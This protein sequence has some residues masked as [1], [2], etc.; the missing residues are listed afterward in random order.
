[1]ETGAQGMRRFEGRG[2]I[3]TGGASGIG[4]ATARRFLAEG[5]RVLIADRNE[6]ALRAAFPEQTGEAPVRTRV[7]DVSDAASVTAMV[8][9]ARA[10]LP[11]LDVLINNAGIATPERFFEISEASWDRTLSTNLKGMFLVGQAVA[12]AMAEQGG[13][14]IVNTASTNGLVG[15][16][17]YA[18]YNA[19]K[20]GVVLLTKSMAIDLAPHGIRVNAVAPGFIRT[21]LTEGAFADEAYFAAYARNKIPLGRV[22]RP[23]EMAA[24]FAFLASDDASFITG[25]TIVADGGQMTS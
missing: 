3:V 2:V 21:P 13:G 15:E 20:G 25:E 23:E 5:A 18:H 6:A 22:G 19:S 8:E 14:A 10:W 16:E 11:R 24:V 1:M 9:A 4:L 17:D 7:T 12:R